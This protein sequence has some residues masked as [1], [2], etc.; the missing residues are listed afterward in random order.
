MKQINKNNRTKH[1]RNIRVQHKWATGIKQKQIRINLNPSQ[2]LILNSLQSKL[3]S[4]LSV[5]VSS[6]V[7]VRTALELFAEHVAM[8]LSEGR[9]EELISMMEGASEYE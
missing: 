1:I 6:I 8:M 5:N 2:Q 4:S 3:K 9:G 7:I